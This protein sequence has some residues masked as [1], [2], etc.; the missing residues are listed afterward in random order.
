MPTKEKDKNI[1]KVEEIKTDGGNILLRG[2]LGVDRDGR[3]VFVEFDPDGLLGRVFIEGDEEA[4]TRIDLGGVACLDMVVA[5]WQA[6]QVVE[7]VAEMYERW[8]RQ[9]ILREASVD[10]LIEALVAKFR[11]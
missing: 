8:E 2:Q 6:P 10:E 4:V 3:R 11:P 9:K 5:G 1:G 7:A